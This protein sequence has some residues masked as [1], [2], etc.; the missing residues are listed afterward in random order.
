MVDHV[1]HL[2]DQSSDVVS[3]VMVSVMHC[4]GSHFQPLF[5]D[6]QTNNLTGWDN[7]ELK[8]ELLCIAS[9]ILSNWNSQLP[10]V[11]YA[12]NSQPNASS[13]GMSPF[14]CLLDYSLHRMMKSDCSISPDPHA[15]LLQDLDARYV[16]TFELESSSILELPASLS[17]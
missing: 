5:Y 8:V 10:W 2:Q 9:V 14:L 4:P 3:K 12:Q 11:K 13:S 17:I 16:G 6:S 1:F 7:E 15:L